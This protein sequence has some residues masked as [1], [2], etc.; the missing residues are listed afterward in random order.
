MA[1]AEKSAPVE[2]ADLFGDSEAHRLFREDP[3]SR[4]LM[5]CGMHADGDGLR[6]RINQ[7]LEE[8]KPGNGEADRARLAR[9]R[10]ANDG[11]LSR[12]HP[13]CEPRAALAQS[14]AA[15]YLI[16]IKDKLA[17]PRGFGPPE[18]MGTPDCEIDGIGPESAKRGRRELIDRGA[19]PEDLARAEALVRSESVKAALRNEE[20]TAWGRPPSEMERI[21]KLGRELPEIDKA[22]ALA[23]LRRAASAYGKIAL[24]ASKAKLGEAELSELLAAGRRELESRC[25]M[26]P[27]DFARLEADPQASLALCRLG[28]GGVRELDAAGWVVAGFREEGRMF[29]T[30]DPLLDEGLGADGEGELVRELVGE[31]GEVLEEELDMAWDEDAAEAAVADPE[32]PWRGA[33]AEEPL[34]KLPP[35]HWSEM[36]I[37]GIWRSALGMEAIGRMWSAL[38]LDDPEQRESA[39]RALLLERTSTGGDRER[40]W[41]GLPAMGDLAMPREAASKNSGSIPGDP[42]RGKSLRLALESYAKILE[43]RA[44]ERMLV[45]RGGE[46]LRK[47]LAGGAGAIALEMA[48]SEALA[49]ERLGGKALGLALDL[50]LRRPDAKADIGAALAR[51][52]A[53]GFAGCGEDPESLLPGIGEIGEEPPKD[54]ADPAWAAGAA[55]AKKDPMG[56]VAMSAL[57][58]SRRGVGNPQGIVGEAKEALRGEFG[59]SAAAWKAIAGNEALR[60]LYG[61][62]LKASAKDDRKPTLWKVVQDTMAQA[63]KS[64]DAAM[65]KLARLSEK[66]LREL[67]AKAASKALSACLMG[68]IGPEGQEG[69]LVAL[70]RSEP[71]RRIIGGLLS[72]EPWLTRSKKIR[73]SDRASEIATGLKEDAQA[74]ERLGPAIAAGLARRMDRE[75]ERRLA[76][77]ESP[78]SA[79]EAAIA[80]AIGDCADIEDASKGLPTGF[81]AGLDPKGPVE[82]AL[83]QHEEWVAIE[84]ARRAREAPSAGI[85][86]PREMREGWAAGRVAIEEISTGLGL[87]E[88]GEEMRHCVS[89]YASYCEAGGCRIFS[90]RMDGLRAATLELKPRGAGGR[91]LEGFDAEKGSSRQSARSW[92][93]E[94][95]RGKRNALVRSKEILEACEAFALDYSKAFEKNTKEILEREAREAEEAKAKIGEKLAGKRRGKAE[96]KGPQA[97]AA[98]GA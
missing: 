85:E 84:R 62:A 7:A 41:E 15:T 40:E 11:E 2:R 81:W 76:A 23:A 10:S 29:R 74:L 57:K 35:G 63:D 50:A 36:G 97:A 59:L 61:K 26:G 80:R 44:P 52:A 16:W 66:A 5:L 69:L 4:L 30:R 21:R 93:I 48:E 91:L 70:E 8:E 43:W 73:A 51:R 12:A 14:Q 71:A 17:R 45:P 25:A 98:K 19:D 88:E 78:K 86:W 20:R 13:L 68:G 82:H 96:G 64:E 32:A 1:K 31:D 27:E 9:I 79:K 33:G 49:H 72:W 60:N 39:T 28:F 42:K 46:A 24:E 22:A 94:Q 55:F 58:A 92:S 67:P 3:F 18:G 83:R 89:S 65:A 56:A 95:N 6:G 77:G 34:A 54:E 47:A 90:V 87:F 37:P 75:R 38:R 53:L